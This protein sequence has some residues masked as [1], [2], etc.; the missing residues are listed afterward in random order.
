MQEAQQNEVA[1]CQRRILPFSGQKS[2]CLPRLSLGKQI[3]LTITVTFTVTES[4]GF[5]PQSGTVKFGRTGGPLQTSTFGPK[6][7]A[8]PASATSMYH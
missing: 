6:T 2:A 7:G 8:G 5:G 1:N 4:S 3:C